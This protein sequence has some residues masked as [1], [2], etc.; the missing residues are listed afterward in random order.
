MFTQIQ[1]AKTTFFT[2]KEHYLSFRKAWATT[3]N[4]PETQRTLTPTHFLLYSLLREKPYNH[5]F[6]PIQRLSKI[7]SRWPKDKWCELIK[8][9]R[10]LGFWIKQ[11]SS[12]TSK[13]YDSETRQ[14]VTSDAKVQGFLKPFGGEI[15]VEMLAKMKDYVPE[16]WQD[17]IVNEPIKVIKA[18]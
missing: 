3:F 16:K 17:I 14:Y 13:V 5:G 1:N 2:S 12:P 15:S 10:M 8:A 11:A 7:E 6:T 18:A 9:H 4:N